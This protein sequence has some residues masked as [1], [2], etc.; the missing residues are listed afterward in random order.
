MFTSTIHNAALS[1]T[2]A[3]LASLALFHGDPTGSGTQVGSTQ[4]LG[5]G[6]PSGGSMS[7][8]E[9]FDVPAGSTV[10]YVAIYDGA[11]TPNLV[12]SQ[13]TIDSSG[14]ATSETWNSAGTASV[15]VTVKAA[16]AA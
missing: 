13:R 5:W 9:Q 10:D 8:S 3:D 4:A 15:S 1:G 16:D 11:S 14:T 7:A 2:Q 6:T 12:G